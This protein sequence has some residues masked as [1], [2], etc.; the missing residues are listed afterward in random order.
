ME[1]GI[2]LGWVINFFVAGSLPEVFKIFVEKAKDYLY[3]RLS[4]GMSNH[5][6]IT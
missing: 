3:G 2:L 1:T 4:D 5:V 6:L